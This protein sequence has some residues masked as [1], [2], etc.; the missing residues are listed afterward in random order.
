M[1]SELKPGYIEYHQGQMLEPNFFTFK[2]ILPVHTPTQ[3]EA[4]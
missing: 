4:S 3:V 2:N 1:L